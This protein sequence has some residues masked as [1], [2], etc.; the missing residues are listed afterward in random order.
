VAA[1]H[2][3]PIELRV[4]SLRMRVRTAIF[5]V[6]SNDAPPQLSTPCAQKLRIKVTRLRVAA[7]R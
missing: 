3:D 1:H 7:G 6:N 4:K 5:V 2:L